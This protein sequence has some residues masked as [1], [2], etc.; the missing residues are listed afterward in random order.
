M[1]NKPNPSSHPATPNPNRL[2]S[3]PQSPE[4]PTGKHPKHPHIQAHSPKLPGR[5]AEML[6]VLQRQQRGSRRAV[7]VEGGEASGEGVGQILV[8]VELVD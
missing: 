8:V 2:E 6:H 4:N 5:G 3:P 1:T 7:I